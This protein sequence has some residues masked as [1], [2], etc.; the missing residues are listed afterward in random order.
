MDQREEDNDG[1]DI[2]ETAMDLFILKTIQYHHWKD[3]TQGAVSPALSEFFRFSDP[4]QPA[5]VHWA[6]WLRIDHESDE[7]I[8]IIDLEDAEELVEA[9]IAHVKVPPTI[10][11]AMRQALHDPGY[12][13]RDP[14]QLQLF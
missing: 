9:M 4:R 12:G 7:G 3:P 1:Y 6:R 2:S 11:H 14:D 13:E 5:L 8:D 10:A